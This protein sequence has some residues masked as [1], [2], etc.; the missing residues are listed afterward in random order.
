MNIKS[1]NDNSTGGHSTMA[2]LTS[3]NW[4]DRRFFP[5]RHLR[6]R[7]NPRRLTLRGLECLEQR[8]LLATFQVTNSNGFGVGSFRQAI[9]DSNH[10]SGPNLI[11]FN[12]F[13]GG[14]VLTGRTSLPAITNTVS[15]DGTTAPSFAGRP[16]VTIDFQG[17]QGLQFSAGSDHSSLTSLS[18]VRAGGD[19]VTL[20]SSFVT[21][22]GN[23]IGVMTDGQT[24]AGNKGDGVKI[25]ASSHGALIGQLSSQKYYDTSQVGTQPV[26]AWQGI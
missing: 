11:A 9:I 23:N 19:G 21:V 7:R 3:T 17:S 1:E 2:M 18:L 16:V 14:T 15:I 22:Q 24:M 20:S 6:R 25:N 12:N 5:G 13:Q 10:T 4:A 8:E 26:S